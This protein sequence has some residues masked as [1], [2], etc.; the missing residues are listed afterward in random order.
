MVVASKRD[1]EE[2]KAVARTVFQTD[3]RWAPFVGC[4]RPGND[5][6]PVIIGPTTNKVE[7][8]ELKGRFEQAKILPDGPFLSFYPY[9][10]AVFTQQ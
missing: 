6:Y 4:K 2:A 8:A 3:K 5:F 9:R 10:K 7:A 1:F